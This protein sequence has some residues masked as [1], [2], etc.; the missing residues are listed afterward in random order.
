MINRDPLREIKIKKLIEL[1]LED[2]NRICTG[3][4]LKNFIEAGHE[5]LTP[6]LKLIDE[7]AAAG[8]EAG[9]KA[10]LRELRRIG[11][12]AISCF[13]HAERR[14]RE[15]KS[16]EKSDSSTDK[17]IIKKSGWANLG[18]S[19]K[20]KPVADW[21]WRGWLRD[22]LLAA[23]VAHGEAGKG[24]LASCLALSVAAGV[25]YL[26]HPCSQGKV[27]IISAEDDTDEMLS[28]LHDIATALGL[29]QDYVL[30]NVAVF[31]TAD[32]GMAPS[33]LSKDMQPSELLLEIKRV[34]CAVKPKLIIMDTLAALAPA[35][36]NLI[37]A[38]VATQYLCG[39]GAILRPPDGPAPAILF[40]HHLRKPEKNSD[41]RPSI[42]DVRD[43]G[44]IVGS[45]RSVLILHK[46]I[47]TLDK[48]N[49]R[50]RVEPEWRVDRDDAYQLQ[51]KSALGCH[52]GAL[53][54]AGK[55]NLIELEA[56]ER[57]RLQDNVDL[58]A[59]RKRE[60]RDAIKQQ[61]AKGN[62]KAF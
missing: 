45:M 39:V 20:P 13:E 60:E 43:S 59:A 53:V 58:R 36:A 11:A 44:A 8:N 28:R 32:A 55:D 18:S 23:L 4:A 25:E 57:Q 54:L 31:S 61:E 52:N 48:C 3:E 19:P 6:T 22:G 50:R 30:K 21:L 62:G 40:T 15:E 37:E 34:V 2:V 5:G 56:A 27:L 24:M 1:T 26:G 42:H 33:L 29:D 49:G 38:T 41:T 51:W 10:G 9:V 46:E 35:G 7:A 17:D 16:T 12:E 14:E 47:L